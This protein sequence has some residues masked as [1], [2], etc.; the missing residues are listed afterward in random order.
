MPIDY[1]MLGQKV[2][3]YRT[4]ASLSQEELADMLNVERSYISKIEKGRAKPSP[5][6]LVGIFLKLSKLQLAAADVC[7]IY[8]L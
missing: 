7:R 6:I 2:A 3:Y 8:H 4:Q 5:D 1:L